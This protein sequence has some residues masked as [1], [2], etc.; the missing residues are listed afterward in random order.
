MKLTAAAVSGKSARARGRRSISNNTANK[1]QGNRSISESR[2]VVHPFDSGGTAGEG[3]QAG[4]RRRSEVR[5]N[6]EC[7]PLGHCFRGRRRVRVMA[8]VKNS[9]SKVC[10]SRSSGLARSAKRLIRRGIIERGIPL[11]DFSFVEDEAS[12]ARLAFI[13]VPETVESVP[14]EQFALLPLKR[15]FSRKDGKSIVLLTDR[16]IVAPGGR[17]HVDA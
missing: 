10:R 15:L 16:G 13:S 3:R 4:G 9:P 6:I 12:D 2:S 11:R 1:T 7:T 17:L 8:E 14:I 5:N